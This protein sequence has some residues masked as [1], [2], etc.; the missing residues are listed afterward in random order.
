MPTVGVGAEA[1]PILINDINIKLYLM[2][3]IN[4]RDHMD[5]VWG[6][7]HSAILLEYGIHERSGNR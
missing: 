7:M 3:L 2:S 1:V 5:R 4:H 6:L